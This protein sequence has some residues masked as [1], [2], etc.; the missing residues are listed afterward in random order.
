MV[1]SDS[2][3]VTLFIPCLTDMLYPQTARDLVV[4][5]KNLGFSVQYPQA[6]T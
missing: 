5:L 2:R 3:A 6:Q 1:S 4:L